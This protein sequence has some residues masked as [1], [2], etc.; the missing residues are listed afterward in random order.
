MNSRRL[1]AISDR[2]LPNWES[3]DRS[4][5]PQKPAIGGLVYYSRYAPVVRPDCLAGAAVLIA[6]VSTQ[7]PC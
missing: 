3:G 4:P 2:N 6:P 1:S 5:K 7:I